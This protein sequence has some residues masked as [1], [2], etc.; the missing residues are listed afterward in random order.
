MNKT[1]ETIEALKN[2]DWF[3]EFANGKTWREGVKKYETAM[4]LLKE[5]PREEAYELFNEH[6]K[7]LYTPKGGGY[8]NPFR[9]E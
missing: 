6:C 8:R 9:E 4:K 5:L 3:Y 7:H 2:V 1:N